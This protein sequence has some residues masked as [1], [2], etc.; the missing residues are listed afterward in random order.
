MAAV[1]TKIE[2]NSINAIMLFP[3]CLLFILTPFLILYY[4]N[5]FLKSENFVQS[6]IVNLVA[7]VVLVAPCKKCKFPGKQTNIPGFGT[8]S[9]FWSGKYKTPPS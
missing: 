8:I 4:T 7:P 1:V 2:I 5:S 3:A 6:D 9:T